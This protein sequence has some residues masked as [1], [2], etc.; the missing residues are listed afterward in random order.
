MLDDF[1]DDESC[2]GS[3]FVTS[4]WDHIYEQP[5]SSSTP[6]PDIFGDNH[7]IG[8]MS[9]NPRTGKIEINGPAGLVAGALGALALF[10]GRGN[11]DSY[12]ER[13]RR[14]EAE[15]EAQKAKRQ[16]EEAER[17][18]EEAEEQAARAQ[19]ENQA[20][21]EKLKLEEELRML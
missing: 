10:A 19:K 4:D 17:A 20:A 13:Q 2:A 16:K 1:S 15:L 6:H 11:N 8:S 14:L 21:Q 12:E 5:L 9:F 18:K 3:N 7:S